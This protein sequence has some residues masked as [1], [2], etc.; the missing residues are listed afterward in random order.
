MP[1]PKDAGT[2]ATT[3]AVGISVRQLYYWVQRCRVV[4]PRLQRHGRRTFQYFSAS[5]VRKLKT[6]K[7][8]L[9]RGYTLR[10]AVKTA[11]RA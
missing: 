7:R 5:D 3:R 8:L 9:E 1:Q 11:S 4:H 10:A 2:I 6:V